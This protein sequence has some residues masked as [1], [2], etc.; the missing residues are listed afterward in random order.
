M[1]DEVLKKV[2]RTVAQQ[3]P[4]LSSVKPRIKRHRDDRR[5]NPQFT[6]TYSG[7]AE[8][9][10]GRKLKRVVRVVVNERGKILK[11]STSK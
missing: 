6:L 11:L 10:G 5:G 4:E 9:P 8:L 3:F 7:M 1:D 2:S